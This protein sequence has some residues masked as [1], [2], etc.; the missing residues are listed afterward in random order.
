MKRST[1]IITGACVLGGTIGVV[2]V[3]PW[4]H[5]P[6]H[7]DAELVSSEPLR[8]VYPDNPFIL[9][10]EAQHSRPTDG[11]PGTAEMKKPWR[12]P[13]ATLQFDARSTTSGALKRTIAALG[14]RVWEAID[15][16]P[17]SQALDEAR[18]STFVESVQEGVR[19]V[20]AADYDAWL[21]RAM[22]WGPRPNVNKERWQ[23]AA[24][25]FK[26]AP[27]GLSHVAVRPLYLHG[28]PMDIPAPP[29]FMRALRLDVYPYTPPEEAHLDVY[30]ALIPV[31]YR[32]TGAH[33]ADAA[34]LLGV[35]FAWN[36]ER[37]EWQPYDL[38]V[39]A[40]AFDGAFSL[41]IM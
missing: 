22:R 27:I 1:R 16:L 18:A 25:G 20:L 10:L 28:K 40:N 26:N 30:E 15:Q 17:P 7:N 21:Q 41:P 31:H 9:K 33:R 11:S 3:K 4:R 8:T 34:A 14:D 6:R 12:I 13:E 23:A 39:Y 35:S 36:A 19:I 24:A 29:S 37:K 2:V 38:V 5:Q 32:T